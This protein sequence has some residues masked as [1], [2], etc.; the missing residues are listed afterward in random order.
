[1]SNTNCEKCLFAD[2]VESDEPCKIH[3]IDMIK[4]EHTTSVKNNFYYIQNY[5]CH[6]GFDLKTYAENKNKIG[7]IEDLKKTIKNNNL[8]SYYLII[9]TDLSK[10]EELCDSINSLTIP[11]RC[12]SLIMHKN[13]NTDQT[14]QTLKTKIN[15]EIEWKIHNFLEETSLAEAIH[16]VLDTNMNKNQSVYFWVNCN[17]DYSS[18]NKDIEN[19]S[20]YITIKQP[21]CHA[22]LRNSSDSLDGLFLPFDNYRTLIKELDPDISKAISLIKNPRIIYYA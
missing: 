13:N 22:L 18:W 9:E 19:I 4:D 17:N 7:S 21:I 16:T 14:I 6:Y 5:K 2:Y 12:V 11:P 20:D 10:I 1:M 3:I 8:L 15:K